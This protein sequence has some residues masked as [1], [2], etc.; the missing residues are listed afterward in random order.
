M[1][2]ESITTWYLILSGFDTMTDR[3]AWKVIQFTALIGCT[4]VQLMPNSKTQ[5]TAIFLQNHFNSLPTETHWLPLHSLSP[6]FLFSLYQYRYL[7]SLSADCPRVDSSQIASFSWRVKNVKI[8]SPNTLGWLL[9]Y[10]DGAP[11]KVY[12]LETLNKNLDSVPALSFSLNVCSN[13]FMIIWKN[14]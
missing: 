6:L 9:M 2:D 8:D 10:P 13:T 7:L 11:S 3:G 5:K 4:S 12:V 1:F 14:F